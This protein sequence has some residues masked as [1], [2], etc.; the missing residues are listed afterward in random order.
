MRWIWYH[1]KQ[2]SSATH[3]NSLRLTATHRN[4]LQ[5]TQHAGC[6]EHD[7][8]PNNCHLQLTATPCASL[9]LTATHCNT[10]SM[11]DVLNMISYQIKVNCSSIA[12]SYRY[13]LWIFFFSYLYFLKIC[14]SSPPVLLNPTGW[15]RPTGC[16]IVTGHFPQKSPVISG[17]F[18]KNEALL[19]KMMQLKA[20]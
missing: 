6:I 4:T 19:R 15:R 13:F 5:H 8:I 2:L 12:L 3:C 1:T 16:L 14:I 9:Q 17:S 11:P 7:I 18:A 10:H 20:S